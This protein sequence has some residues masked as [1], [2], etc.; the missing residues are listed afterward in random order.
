MVAARNVLMVDEALTT[1][2]D[3]TPTSNTWGAF[4]KAISIKVQQYVFV[5]LRDLLGRSLRNRKVMDVILADT[6]PSIDLTT[7]LAPYARYLDLHNQVENWFEELH[8]RGHNY[9]Y[10][11]YLP[12]LIKPRLVKWTKTVPLSHEI[13]DVVEEIR[14][15]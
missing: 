8:E 9:N 11:A 2:I 1:K 13:I 7:F 5:V 6:F 12:H 3:K 4:T 14:D 15:V 10:L